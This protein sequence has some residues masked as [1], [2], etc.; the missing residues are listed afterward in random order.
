MNSKWAHCE[1]KTD[2]TYSDEKTGEYIPYKCDEPEHILNSKLC[3]FHHQDP[4][5]KEANKRR[6]EVESF[7][8]YRNECGIIRCC[9]QDSWWCCNIWFDYHSFK[10][11][12]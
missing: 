1:F 9:F 6:I 5:I 8:W 11:K 2:I 12:V 10:K 7:F 4:K 3:I